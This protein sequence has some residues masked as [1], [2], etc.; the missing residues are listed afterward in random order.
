LDHGCDWEPWGAKLL[1]I[2]W[3]KSRQHECPTVTGFEEP[4]RMGLKVSNRREL[5]QV[6]TLLG[7]RL[8]KVG[9]WAWDS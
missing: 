5:E 4:K 3:R 9:S 7:V 2:F 6:G 8:L 1:F